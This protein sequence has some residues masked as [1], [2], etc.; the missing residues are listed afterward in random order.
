MAHHLSQF[1][2]VLPVNQASLFKF[3]W[4][5]QIKEGARHK[6]QI[7]GLVY[8]YPIAA[9]L[10]AYQ[11]ACALAESSHVLMLVHEDC[12]SIWV[13]LKDTEFWRRTSVSQ[14]QPLMTA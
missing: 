12:Y 11:R 1:P 14:D 9:R 13:C 3:Y 2:V 8:Q 10:V 6:G 4:Q 7:Y 5:Q